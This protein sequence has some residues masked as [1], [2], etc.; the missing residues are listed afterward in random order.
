[1]SI[2]YLQFDSPDDD[3]AD[4]T[5]IAIEERAAYEY[6]ARFFANINKQLEDRD[7]EVDY[8]DDYE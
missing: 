8:G 3:Y 4:L 6:E 2:S 5:R 1:M 7:P